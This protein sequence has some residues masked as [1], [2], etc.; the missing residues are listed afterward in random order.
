MDFDYEIIYLPSAEN[1]VA[2][3]LSQRE[4]GLLLLPITGPMCTIWQQIRNAL[5]TNQRTQELIQAIEEGTSHDDYEFRNG[6]LMYRDEHTCETCRICRLILSAISTIQEKE[7]IQ[8]V[9]ALGKD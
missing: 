7:A 2:K 6:L 3:A 4:D 8:E 9:T 1:K 5:L